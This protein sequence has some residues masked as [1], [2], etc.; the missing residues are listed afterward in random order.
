[1]IVLIAIVDLLVPRG[2]ST[3]DAICFFVEG[4]YG[5]R[6][7]MFRGDG[8]VF[9]VI[10][11]IAGAR[12]MG[13]TVILP[14]G[15]R[16]TYGHGTMF[17]TAKGAVF[18]VSTACAGP[19]GTGATGCTTRVRLGL[20]SNTAC[21][22]FVAQGNFGSL[23]VR[24]LSSGRTRGVLGSGGFMTLSSCSRMGWSTCRGCVNCRSV[25]VSGSAF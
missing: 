13:S 7:S 20:V 1:M 23:G 4:V 2:V 22:I 11:P 17:T 15:A 6:L 19:M 8:P 10:K 18:D 21:C 14:L 25:S 3:R 24:L 16:T 5:A 9:S 12:R